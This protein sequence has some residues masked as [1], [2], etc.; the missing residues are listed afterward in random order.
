MQLE[1]TTLL[2]APGVGENVPAMHAVH[3]PLVEMFAP[4]LYVPGEQAAHAERPARLEYV[5][6]WQTEQTEPFTIWP[7]GQVVQELPEPSEV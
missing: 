1:H 4:E 2:V 3:A 7:G 5:P 6:A